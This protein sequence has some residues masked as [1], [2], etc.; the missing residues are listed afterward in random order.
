MLATRIK[1]KAL[2]KQ[3]ISGTDD[4][5]YVGSLQAVQDNPSSISWLNI[6]TTKTVSFHEPD[7]PTLNLP[8]LNLPAFSIM[9][10]GEKKSPFRLLS[11]QVIDVSVKEKPKTNMNYANQ[12]R[13]SKDY[14]VH[15][16]NEAFPP[17][18]P[19]SRSSSCEDLHAAVSMLGKPGSTPYPSSEN[20]KKLAEEEAEKPSLVSSAAIPIKKS[21]K[22]LGFS[23]KG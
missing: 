8:V 2:S 18:N 22:K 13:G 16:F 17:S 20:L 3:Q 5:F 14:G 7:S 23:L 6:E 1:N 11:G 19:S 4:D 12:N 21:G 15:S 9:R 10:N